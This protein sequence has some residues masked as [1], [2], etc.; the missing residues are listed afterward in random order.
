[1]KDSDI[2]LPKYV[3][4]YGFSHFIRSGISLT[5]VV[6]GDGDGH[7]N[8]CRMGLHRKGT[9]EPTGSA[10]RKSAKPNSGES[11]RLKPRVSSAVADSKREQQE[12]EKTDLPTQLPKASLVR[13]YNV[14]SVHS[15]RCKQANV[16]FWC[17]AMM[18]LML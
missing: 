12:M 16:T 6:G 4:V 7:G 9:H 1:M 13:L 5:C 2:E 3:A 11:T 18:S 15:N 14:R 8:G 17:V 10:E